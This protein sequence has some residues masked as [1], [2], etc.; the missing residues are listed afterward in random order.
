M[1]INLESLSIKELKKLQDQAA[2]MVEQK[3]QVKIEEAREQVRQIADS[4]GMSVEEL[5]GLKKASGKAKS[6]RQKVEPK[7]RNPENPSETWA[8]RGRKPLWLQAKLDQGQS[9]E[10]FLI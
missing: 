5:M 2:A 8:G 3:R 10:S 1:T 7:Y 4:V 9:L 6:P